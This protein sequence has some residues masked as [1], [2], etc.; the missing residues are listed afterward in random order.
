MSSQNLVPSKTAADVW[1]GISLTLLAFWEFHLVKEL[2]DQRGEKNV[3]ACGESFCLKLTSPSWVMP[4]SWL[5]LKIHY[6]LRVVGS[7]SES[8]AVQ[9]D[10]NESKEYF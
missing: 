7:L 8:A 2:L 6:S 4:M 10:S 9:M 3:E 5:H 1:E